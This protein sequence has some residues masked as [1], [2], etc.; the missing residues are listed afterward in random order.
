VDGSSTREEG[1]TGLGLA[2]TRNLVEAHGGI[3][4]VAS[5]QGKGSTFTVLLPVEQAA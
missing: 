5:E 2:I 4:E 3:I 1:G